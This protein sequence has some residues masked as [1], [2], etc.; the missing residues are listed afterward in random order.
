MKCVVATSR[1]LQRTCIS[2]GDG[3]RGAKIL[4]LFKRVATADACIAHSAG[5]YETCSFIIQRQTQ[6][7][8]DATKDRCCRRSVSTLHCT[9]D[10][11]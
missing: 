11:Q 3:E 10:A 7:V 2:G 1:A 8:G 4:L 5:R 6:P 9:A